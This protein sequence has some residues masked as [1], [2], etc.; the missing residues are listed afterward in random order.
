MK[1]A[2]LSCGSLAK[3]RG[4]TVHTVELARNLIQLGAEVVILA[5]SLGRS[6][7][8]GLKIDYA[9]VI[10]IRLLRFLSL[11]ISLTAFVLRRLLSRGTDIIYVREA[12]LYLAPYI[13]G[14]IFRKPA[15]IEINNAAIDD[16]PA[17]PRNFILYP[18][19]IARKISFLLAD[20][21]IVANSAVRDILSKEYGIGIDKFAIIPMGANTD[22]FRPIER[23]KAIEKTG[24][25]NRRKYVGFAGTLY[26]FQGLKYLIDASPLVLEKRRDVRFLIVGSGVEERNI[27]ELIKKKGMEGYFILTGGIEYPEIP[28]YINSMDLCVSIVTPE[29][30]ATHSFPIKIYEYLACG[31]PIVIGNLKAESEL[32]GTKVT[33]VVNASD[34]KALAEAIIDTLEQA[35]SFK[36][37]SERLRKIVSENFSWRMTAEKTMKLFKTI[38]AE[39]E[40]AA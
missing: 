25:E 34:P 3:K 32:L 4:Y 18:K 11:R 12:H 21:I 8:K 6:G 30:S 38:E 10:N 5:P 39:Y 22:L 23:E 20:K 33:P 27:K 9:P 29:R 17:G 14:K 35:D 19:F 7:E 15:V 36:E 28:Y 13:L 31:R 1:I 26:P 24:L 40:H 16:C 37:E 2:Y